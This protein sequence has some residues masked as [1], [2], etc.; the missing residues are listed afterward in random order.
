[1]EG[2]GKNWIPWEAVIGFLYVSCQ[3][4][5]ALALVVG[6]LDLVHQATPK[7]GSLVL[8]SVSV[9]VCMAPVVSE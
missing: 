9:Y 2:H 8:S 7:V 6:T 3:T 5:Q 4:A 1:M